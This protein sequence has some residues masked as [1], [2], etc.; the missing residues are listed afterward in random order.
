MYLQYGYFKRLQSGEMLLIE[1]GP[2]KLSQLIGE[3]KA[4]QEHRVYEMKQMTLDR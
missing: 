4:E 1:L 2:R 3:L